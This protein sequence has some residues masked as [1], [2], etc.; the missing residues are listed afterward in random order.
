MLDDAKKRGSRTNTRSLK[1]ILQ[2]YVDA[3]YTNDIIQQ[4]LDW[5]TQ[6]GLYSD[7]D[8]A[9]QYWGGISGTY[10]GVNKPEK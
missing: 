9:S 5:G 2:A 3:G 1:S 8:Q 6:S 4:T 7:A 10:K